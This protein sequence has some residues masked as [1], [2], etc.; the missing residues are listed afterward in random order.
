MES[1]LVSK[2]NLETKPRVYRFDVFKG[3]QEES[4]KIQKLRTMGEAFHV[5]GQKTFRVTIHTVKEI[6]YFLL[7]EKKF[8]G[9]DFT[10]LRR[11][12]SHDAKRKFL[13]TTVGEGKILTGINSGLMQ[14]NW[15]LFGANDV[16][17][18]LHPKIEVE[19]S[20]DPDS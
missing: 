13:W 10:I 5:D 9:R 8:L 14:L 6:E 17:M 1:N 4:G 16:F 11:E 7:P 12:P 2:L 3:T 15:D 18:N 19:P 20:M